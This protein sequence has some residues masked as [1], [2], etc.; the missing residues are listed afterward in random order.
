MHLLLYPL[1]YPLLVRL[2]EAIFED[3]I[4]VSQFFLFPSTLLST[5]PESPAVEA[6]ESP[7]VEASHSPAVE[8][9]KFSCC[10]CLRNY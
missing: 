6:S 8:A 3:P 7:A 5:H 2:M 1:L 4:S 10:R 9:S